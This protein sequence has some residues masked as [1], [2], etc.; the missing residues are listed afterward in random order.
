MTIVHSGNRKD[1]AFMKLQEE[2]LKVSTD[3]TLFAWDYNESHKIQVDV[4]Q[5]GI[6]ILAPDPS[7]FRDCDNVVETDDAEPSVQEFTMTNVGLTMTS[8][9]VSTND[10]AIVYA[11][12]NCTHE[13]DINTRICVP[14]TS[15]RRSRG[16]LADARPKPELTRNPFYLPSLLSIETRRIPKQFVKICILR[17][18]PTHWDQLGGWRRDDP[19]KT[20]VVI[21]LFP[22]DGALEGWTVDRYF[23]SP[24]DILKFYSPF[25]NT[26]GRHEHT[27][28]GC[29]LEFR[30]QTWQEHNKRRILAITWSE[31]FSRTHACFRTLMGAGDIDGKNLIEL[32][33]H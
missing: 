24:Q 32:A 13:G 27:S 28:M 22:S 16:R 9:L 10:S 3:Q 12:L 20:N 29:F 11:A 5:T 18:S 19:H 25:I 6:S 1:L 15:M 8:G 26:G 17:M 30:S 7:Y 21:Q 4:A 14:L 33:W 31:D 2:I 23:V